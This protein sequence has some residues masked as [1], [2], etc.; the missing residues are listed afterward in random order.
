MNTIPKSDLQ[1]LLDHC[2]EMSTALNHRGEI[3]AQ[4]LMIKLIERLRM[5]DAE[6][7]RLRDW[8]SPSA[9]VADSDVLRGTMDY[10]KLALNPDDPQEAVILIAGYNKSAWLLVRQ[11]VVILSAERFDAMN[12]GRLTAQTDAITRLQAEIAELRKDKERLDSGMIIIQA[13]DRTTCWFT[14]RNLRED[15]DAAVSAAKGTQPL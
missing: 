9:P 15:I 2:K 7:V 11:P 13:V 12:K 4:N 5:M 1:E 3:T 6:I 14:G 8:Q 10:L